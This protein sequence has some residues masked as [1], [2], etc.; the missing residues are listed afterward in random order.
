[1]IV[2]VDGPAGSGKGTLTK[3]VADKLNLQYIDTGAMYRCIAFKMLEDGIS[4]EDT[5][6]IKEI[7][8]DIE[9]DLQGT[10]VILNGRDVSKEI[11]TVEVAN[12]TS[13]VSAIDF[14]RTKMV[15]LQRGLA[16][17]KNIIMEGR[18]IG[19]VVFPNADVKIYLDASAEERARR[20]VRQNEE[21]G[22]SSNYEQIL[23]D[24]I[25]RDTRDMSRPNSPLKKAEDA[26]VVD[27]TD[28]EAEVN[29]QKIIDVIKSK[30]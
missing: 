7:L 25:E 13:P 29:A 26:V 12:F 6:K 18:D 23:K 16:K 4:L 2:A 5:D 15:E 30:I 9:I 19:T 21:N 10:K 14:I 27:T 3:L 1:M 24:I 11:R 17:E 20:R 8:D 22:I 28:A